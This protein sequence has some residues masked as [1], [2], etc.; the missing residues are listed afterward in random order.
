MK[1]HHSQPECDLEALGTHGQ[2]CP[3]VFH[4]VSSNAGVQVTW[5]DVYSECSASASCW[6]W[7]DLGGGPSRKVQARLLEKCAPLLDFCTMKYF[8]LT[9]NIPDILYSVSLCQ[10]QTQHTSNIK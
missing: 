10:I 4:D 2:I 1:A 9:S 8:E 5:G 6:D 3:D 7:D